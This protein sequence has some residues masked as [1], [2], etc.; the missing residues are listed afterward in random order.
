[1][2]DDEV[3]SVGKGGNLRGIDELAGHHVIGDASQCGDLG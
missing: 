3:R 2:C 1:M